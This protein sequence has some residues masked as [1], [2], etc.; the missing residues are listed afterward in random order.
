MLSELHI[1]NFRAFEDLTIS[2]LKRVNLIAGKN[3]SGK[4][5]VLEAL[6]IWA[7]DAD[8]T[9]VN[10]V[11]HLRGQFKPSHQNSFEALFNGKVS[12]GGNQLEI[13]ELIIKKT[14]T[15]Q[16]TVHGIQMAYS[17]GNLIPPVYL[18]AN[19]SP[20]YPND[21][22][23]Y[24]PFTGS[25]TPLSGLW[26]KVALTDLEDDVIRIMRETVEPRIIRLD[27]TTGNAKVRLEGSSVPIP[28]QV[29]GDGVQRMLLL[30][31]TLVNAKGKMLLIDEFE[32]G[33]HHSV[34]ERLWELV[35]EYAQ[36]WDIQV[37]VTTHS[38]DTIRK[39]LYTAS[40]VENEGQAFFVRLQ[41]GRSGEIEAVPYE[42]ERLE[43]ALEM[44]LEIR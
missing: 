20:D 26:D 15:S 19:H 44:N 38:E 42:M 10:N 25:H 31:L 18:N 11:L 14:P 27:V 6:R 4:T 12:K 1:R 39:F 8:S 43:N 37:F 34:Q 24:V 40:K 23:V 3:N 16:G 41:F 2:G 29:L 13:N 5:T 28:I 35:F 30:A 17:I 33:L 32:A 9:V 7:S 36:K 22:V 21:Q